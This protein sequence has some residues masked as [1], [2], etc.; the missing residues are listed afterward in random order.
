MRWTSSSN[1]CSNLSYNSLAFFVVFLIDWKILKSFLCS[2]L[3]FFLHCIVIFILPTK[4]TLT[5]CKLVSHNYSNFCTLLQR[6]VHA[7]SKHI[8]KQSGQPCDPFPTLKSFLFTV[9][10]ANLSN[11]SV[12]CVFSS[13]SLGHWEQSCNNCYIKLI[14]PLGAK[15][16]EI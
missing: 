11:S 6:K 13:A 1:T 14:G 9:H 8:T 5:L 4:A 15:G 7:M 16:W 2:A 12:S 3:A 10:S